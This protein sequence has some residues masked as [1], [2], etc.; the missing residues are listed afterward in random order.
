MGPIRYDTKF[1]LNNRV[2]NKKTD[3]SFRTC[4]LAPKN[5]SKTGHADSV[6]LF[7]FL[8]LLKNEEASVNFFC[9]DSMRRLASMED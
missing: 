7:P 3:R 6:T 1:P 2:Q 9:K 5:N 4:P 8:K